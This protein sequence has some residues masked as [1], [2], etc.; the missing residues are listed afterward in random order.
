MVIQSIVEKALDYLEPCIVRINDQ[1]LTP[2]IAWAVSTAACEAATLAL[3]EKALRILGVVEAQGVFLP[4][5]PSR[6]TL[7]MKW[8]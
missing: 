7:T 2:C 3:R 8:Q 6:D 4:N 1:D 5:M